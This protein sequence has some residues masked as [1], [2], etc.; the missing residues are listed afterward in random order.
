MIEEVEEEKG[1]VEEEESKEEEFCTLILC[2]GTF[3]KTY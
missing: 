3:L 1:E 2:K